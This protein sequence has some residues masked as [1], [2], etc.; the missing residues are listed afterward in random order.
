MDGQR[1]QRQLLGNFEDATKMVSAEKV[2]TASLI[3]PMMHQFDRHLVVKD[4]D[5]PI[6]KNCKAAIAKM[7]DT[8]C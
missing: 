6:V 1:E 7:A 5:T 4:D 8:C 2:P 3:L